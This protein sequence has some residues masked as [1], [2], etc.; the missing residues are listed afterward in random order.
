VIK[1]LKKLFK[2]KKLTNVQWWDKYRAYL[3]SRKWQ[4]IRARVLKRDKHRCT[5]R[6]LMFFRCS[7]KTY[8]QVHHVHYRY[9]FNETKDLRCLKTLCEKHHK[10]EHQKKKAKKLAKD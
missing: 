1:W 4:A 3:N 9:V 10:L 8:L 2:K 6:V 5:Y 7:A